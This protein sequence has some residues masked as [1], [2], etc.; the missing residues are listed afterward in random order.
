MH[1]LGRKFQ[2]YPPRSV[3]TLHMRPDQALEEAGVVVENRGE[4]EE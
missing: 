3:G 2:C 1:V 4:E